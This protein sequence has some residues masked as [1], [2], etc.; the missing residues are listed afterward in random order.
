MT[1]GNNQSESDG[2]CLDVTY[3]EISRLKRLRKLYLFID[4]E[5]GTIHRDQYSE[6]NVKGNQPIK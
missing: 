3:P 1:Y 2:K 5:Q 6:M 4:E